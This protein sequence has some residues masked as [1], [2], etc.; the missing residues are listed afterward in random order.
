MNN[1]QFKSNKQSTISAL[2]FLTLSLGVS[3]PA[4]A[5]VNDHDGNH[6]D[7]DAN[8]VI[9]A[10]PMPAGPSYPGCALE[11]GV[12]TGHDGGISYEWTVK[13]GKKG[14]VQFVNRVGAKSWN[15]PPPAYEPP[16]TGWTHT[17]NWVALELSERTNLRIEVERQEGVPYT[18]G[19][20]IVTARN[21]LVPAISV[22]SGWDSTSC[23]DHRYNTAGN[24]DWSTIN[25]IG[26]EPNAK[27][28]S[29]A[30]YSVKLDA[31]QYSIAIGGSP[32]V[33]DTYPAGDCDPLDKQCYAYTG[34]H[35][36]R[37]NLETN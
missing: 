37:A 29:V 35:G 30:V 34:N 7:T 10:D 16:D 5:T 22:Y 6:H 24:V 26:N 18:S 4:V 20:S 36:Y 2:A 15:E 8:T 12:P 32:K 13:M 21:M 14:K 31:G 1:V 23:E 3:L 27:G 11:G 19:T 25:F 28:K 9:Y 33:L 17:S